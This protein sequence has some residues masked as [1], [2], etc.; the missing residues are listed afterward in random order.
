MFD[1]YYNNDNFEGKTEVL[2][3]QRGFVITRLLL[4]FRTPSKKN[5]KK[6]NELLNKEAFCVYAIQDK[7]FY[8]LVRETALVQILNLSVNNYEM[9]V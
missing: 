6:L 8:K 4:F 1:L 3:L 7:D 9:L 2:R 5:G